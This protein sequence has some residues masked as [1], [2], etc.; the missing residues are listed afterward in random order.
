MIKV[1]IVIILVTLAI[2]N[3][4]GLDFKSLGRHV[5]RCKEKL[6]Q[7]CNGADRLPTPPNVT[8]ESLMN[9][10]QHTNTSIVKCCCEKQCKGLHRLKPHQRSCRPLF[11]LQKEILEGIEYNQ[12]KNNDVL[13]IDIENQVNSLP[14]VKTGF[15]LP[16]T[17]NHWNIANSY[18][19][20]TLPVSLIDIEDLIATIK[21]MNDTI[22]NYFKDNY[23]AV[24]TNTYKIY[25]EKYKEFNRH[26]L[27]RELKK[28]KESEADKEE[29]KSFAKL[30]RS[31]LKGTEDDSNVNDFYSVDH[32]SLAKKNIWSYAKKF[33]EKKRAVVPT[34]DYNKCYEYFNSVFKAV[35]PSKVF[36]IPS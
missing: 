3:Y 10:S 18:F 25:H 22:Y 8:E 12:S 11:G 9:T 29:I 20:S 21:C 13:D 36:R 15:K 1:V 14:D 2:C 31:R 24:E 34:F 5:W 7:N 35:N 33:I 16:K 26:K 27:K 28:L 23:G 19:K 17:D 30:L 4:C 32:N 6:N